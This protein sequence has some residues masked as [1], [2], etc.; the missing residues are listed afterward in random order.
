MNQ[1]TRRAILDA[2]FTKA[3]VRNL[4]PRPTG[5]TSLFDRLLPFEPP[6][7]RIAI[8]KRLL[9]LDPLRE[10]SNIA[11]MTALADTGERAMALQHYST[12]RD[13]LKSELNVQPGQEV[14]ELKVRLAKSAPPKPAAIFSAAF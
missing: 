8:A 1:Q 2:A 7:E 13:M 3:G 4:P 12:F 6:V 9:A 5:M 11:L 14:E 10:A